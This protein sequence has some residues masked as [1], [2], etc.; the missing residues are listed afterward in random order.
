MKAPLFIAFVLLVSSSISAQDS[1]AAKEHARFWCDCIGKTDPT[2]PEDSIVQQVEDCQSLSITHLLNNKFI[3][4]EALLD[5]A[6]HAQLNATTIALMLRD[7][8]ILQELLAPKEK[9]SYREENPDNIFTPASFFATYGME[10]G[11]TNARLRV[12]N[13]KDKEN[14][15]QRC[16]D[17]RWVFENNKDA[18]SWYQ[19]NLEKNAEGGEPVKENLA[20]ADAEML[21][22]FRES[23]ATVDMMKSFGMVQRHHYFILITGNVVC[24][25]FVATD[26]TVNT[27]DLLPFAA[28]AAKQVKANMPK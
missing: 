28:A 11:E 5:S 23:K 7:C 13:M 8:A 6:Q 2:L 24:K 27:K 21:A 4:S 19:T 3:T 26:G 12:Y 17:I 15:Y 20:V 9:V 1:T 25:V 18:I 16:V 22:V 14:K 10:A